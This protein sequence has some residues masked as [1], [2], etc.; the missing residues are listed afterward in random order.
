[1]NDWGLVPEDGAN[2][3]KYSSLSHN[4]IREILSP[5]TEYTNGS[6]DRFAC[7]SSGEM[8]IKT[9]E[10]KH[11]RG[12]HSSDASSCHRHSERNV[13]EGIVGSGHHPTP[14]QDEEGRLPFPG[15]S[16]ILQFLPFVTHNHIRSVLI[17]PWMAGSQRN[18]DLGVLLPV[19]RFYR[20]GWDRS[21]EDD[22]DIWPAAPLGL[23]RGRPKTPARS[24]ACQ[25][26]FQ[27]PDDQPCP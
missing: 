20:A 12:R 18:P 25:R 7:R 3:P 11:W 10:F 14:P 19:K 4:G 5:L 24:D 15:L 8:P 2:V 9:L 21:A 1:M 23:F 16:A 17:T 26:H 22:A 27:L 6:D 13:V